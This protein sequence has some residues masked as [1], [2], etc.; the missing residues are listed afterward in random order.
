MRVIKHGLAPGDRVIQSGMQ[1]V[2]PGVPVHVQERRDAARP[3]AT[4]ATRP[5]VESPPSAATPPTR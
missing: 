3:R 5:A 2:R 4:P 1:R